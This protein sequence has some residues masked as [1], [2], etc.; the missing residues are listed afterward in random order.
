MIIRPAANQ[1]EADRAY[2][3]EEA[4]YTPEAAASREAFRLRQQTFGSYFLIAETENGDLVGVTNGVRLSHDRI[5]EEGTKQM[6]GFDEQGRYFV[7]LTV[8]VSSAY[9]GRGI[10]KALMQAVKE[11]A[12]RDRLEAVLLMCEAPLIPFYEALGCRYDKPSASTHGGIAWHEM[13]LQLTNSQ[14]GAEVSRG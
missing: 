2:T 4:S 11:Q 10:A 13:R 12:V 7:V 6:E 14:A 5:D 3:I 9:R 1:T 8:A